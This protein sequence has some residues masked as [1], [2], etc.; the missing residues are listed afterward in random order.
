MNHT[1]QTE[2]QNTTKRSL[3]NTVSGTVITTDMQTQ[4]LADIKTST[5][6]YNEAIDADRPETGHTRLPTVLIYIIVCSSLTCLFLLTLVKRRTLL[7]KWK[8]N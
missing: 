6:I 7:C 8:R 4:R 2:L 3:Y 5:T 1:T